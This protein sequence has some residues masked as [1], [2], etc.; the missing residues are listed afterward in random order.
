MTLAHAARR[1]EFSN[2]SFF[3]VPI[4]NKFFFANGL[5]LALVFMM[6]CEVSPS[7]LQG[8]PPVQ[9]GPAV[10]ELAPE[11]VGR[12]LDGVK[13]SLSDYRGKVVFLD[14]YSDS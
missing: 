7:T 3:G 8:G 12:D 11:I 2:I 14:F 6:G 5:V 10:N 1:L 13:F 9:G 4:V